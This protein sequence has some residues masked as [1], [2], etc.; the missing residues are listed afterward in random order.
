MPLFAIHVKCPQCPDAH[1]TGIVLMIDD[2]PIAEQSIAAF[3]GDNPVPLD[4]SFRNETFRCPVTG[5]EF[6]AKT[7]D[8]L[9]IVPAR[10]R[11]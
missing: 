7:D 11:F 8:E 1:T 10:H 2:G 9:L 3:C 5:E 4:L 6:K